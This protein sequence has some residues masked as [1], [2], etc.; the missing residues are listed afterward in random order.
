VFLIAPLLP[1]ALGAGSHLAAAVLLLLKPPHCVYSQ[2][3]SG[4]GG[5]IF[6]KSAYVGVICAHGLTSLRQGDHEYSVH[7][8]AVGTAPPTKSQQWQRQQWPRYLI[9]AR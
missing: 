1:P 6:R 5:H 7:Q 3:V 4:G 2:C 8:A 9:G